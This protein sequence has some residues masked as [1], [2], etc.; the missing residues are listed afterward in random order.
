MKRRR[1]F[2]QVS[3]EFGEIESY[4]SGLEFDRAFGGCSTHIRRNNVHSEMR[5]GDAVQVK[6]QWRGFERVFRFIRVQ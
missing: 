3:N 5:I 6:R 4:Q 1:Y 2:M